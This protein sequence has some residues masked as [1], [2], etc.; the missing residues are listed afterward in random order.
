MFAFRPYI[1]FQDK[2]ALQYIGIKKCSSAG[3][4]D[5]LI[6]LSHIHSSHFPTTGRS[7]WTYNRVISSL[8]S[9]LDTG[10]CR[11]DSG[12]PASCGCCLE[13]R[14]GSATLILVPCI[15]PTMCNLRVI[16]DSCQVSVS[17]VLQ[18]IELVCQ[19][20]HCSLND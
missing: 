6:P 12:S 10:A 11:P 18:Q 20:M 1:L 16:V 9:R 17:D 3:L 4:Y 14:P 15:F 19:A 5:S 7:C 2:R 13:G 8:Q